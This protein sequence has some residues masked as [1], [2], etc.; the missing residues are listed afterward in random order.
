MILMKIFPYILLF[1]LLPLMAE[2]LVYKTF[3]LGFHAED[4]ARI[5]KNDFLSDDGKIYSLGRGS[6]FVRDRESV[7]SEIESFL[8]S[9]AGVQAKSLL[10]RLKDNRHEEKDQLDIKGQIKTN[11]LTGRIELGQQNIK[12]HTNSTLSVTTLN[13]HVGKFTDLRKTEELTVYRN[14]YLSL[15][16]KETFQD[17]FEFEVLPVIQG[18]YVKVVLKR[19]YYATI[20]GKRRSFKESTIET[21]RLVKLGQWTHLAESNSSS[22]NKQRSITGLQLGNQSVT[23]GF[24]M[25]IR[26]DIQGGVEAAEQNQYLLVPKKHSKDLLK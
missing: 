18:D 4:K 11:P 20:N 14:R 5:I 15:Y 2:K 10:V 16:L 8:K 1:C 25:D 23:S 19:N 24:N 21:T 17:G 3:Y 13:G 6:Y 12:S 9:Q 22:E 26:V 7:L